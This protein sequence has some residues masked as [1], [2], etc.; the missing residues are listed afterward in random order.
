MTTARRWADRASASRYPLPISGTATFSSCA[1]SGVHF[2]IDITDLSAREI[3]A[4]SY[5]SSSVPDHHWTLTVD[6]HVWP[7][8]PV[9]SVK[10]QRPDKEQPQPLL[11]THIDCWHTHGLIARATLSLKLA[12]E[13]TDY[14]IVVNH[15][16]VELAPTPPNEHTL[17]A[18]IPQP[19]SQMTLDASL[20][21]HACSPTSVAMLLPNSALDTVLTLCRDNATGMFGSWPLAVRAAARHGAVGAVELNQDWQIAQTVLGE[22]LPFAASIR[23]DKGGLP[24]APLERTSGHLVVVYGID[25]NDVLICDPA[26]PDNG[27]VARRYPVE[28]FSRAWLTHR[29][30]SY[31]IV[32]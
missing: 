16:P 19:L 4:P 12:Q 11:S 2:D 5:S 26:A 10:D 7:L 9:P 27:S 8:L 15:R 30:A 25:G 13:P 18:R 17:A 14:L 20:K 6:G 23:F 28:A 32:P 3:I 22:G 31:I 29:G 1:A 21:H 24:G